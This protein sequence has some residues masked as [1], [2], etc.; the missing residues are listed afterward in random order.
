[1]KKKLTNENIG[2]S[3]LFITAAVIFLCIGAVY[4]VKSAN[5]SNQKPKK[6][7]LS[8]TIGDPNAD[9]RIVEHLDFQCSACAKGYFLLKRYLEKYPSRIQL[10]LKYFP[11]TKQRHA[12]ESAL[13]AE[14]SARQG[15]FWEFSK[16]LLRKQKLWRKLSVDDAQLMFREIAHEVGLDEFDLADCT[17]DELIKQSILSE[18]K[19]GKLLG[20]K[21]TPTYFINGKMVVGVKN[22]QR[23]L[24]TIF[25]EKLEKQ[26]GQRGHE[27][28][29]HE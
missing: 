14:C 19:E 25:G 24:A 6:V 8:R 13:F 28:H 9:I 7:R 21:Q 1:M 11:W 3:K 26:E 18:R 15:K 12:F 4:W 20:I 17:M 29:S 10:E 2:K 22:L 23:E 16:L 27:G 5:R